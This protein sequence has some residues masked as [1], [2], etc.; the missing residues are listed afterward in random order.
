MKRSEKK[1][2]SLSPPPKTRSV[3]GADSGSS[4]CSFTEPCKTKTSIINNELKPLAELHYLNLNNFT[5]LYVIGM[6]MME[7]PARG[8]ELSWGSVRD[9]QQL[10]SEEKKI[11]SDYYYLFQVKNN[12]KICQQYLWH[13]T[14]S[15]YGVRKTFYKKKII[16]F[17]AFT[18]LYNFVF[19][20][21]CC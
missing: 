6:V 19:L 1:L 18:M 17:K 21:K 5:C 15:K 16:L 4:S 9:D 2:P 20:N 14:A 12:L 10:V 13:V 3:C 8:T 11:L 7:C